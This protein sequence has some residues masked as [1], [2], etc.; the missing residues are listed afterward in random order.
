MSKSQQ[1]KGRSGE[2]ELCRFLQDYGI[3]AE[4]GAALNYGKEPDIKG[5]AG[6][7]CECKRA[8]TLRLSEWMA[9]AERDSQRFGDGAPAVFFRRSRE[10]WRVV[11]NLPDW[12]EL[13]QRSQG[14]K[15]GG[16]CSASENQKGD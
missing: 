2:L 16:R 6:I 14:C 12:M 11:M 9:Q 5:V 4:P 7:H 1:R 8:E 3:P 13:Y 10:G 15:C